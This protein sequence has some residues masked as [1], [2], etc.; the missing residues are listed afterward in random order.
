MSDVLEKIEA[1]AEEIAALGPSNEKL[2]RL[3]DRTA[4]LL[5]ESGVIR[6][7]QPA[8][9]GGAE[10]HPADFA[11]AV[12][13]LAS[14]DGST[15]WV[16][17]IVGVH[18]WEMAMCDP[19]V[20]EEIW[21][22]DHDTWIASPYAPMG[23]I[24]PVD[25]GYVFNGRWQFSSGTDHC[26]WIFLGAYLGDESGEAIM[27]P[28]VHHVILPRSD[29]T[30]VEDSWDV[31]GLRGT[32]SKDIVVKD[33]FIPDY[34]VV[35]FS[36]FTDGSQPRD[37][38]LTNPTYHIPFTTAFPLGITSAVIGIAEG[39]LAA[40][41]AYQRTRV[42]IT[43]TKVKDDPY[44][45]YA[46]SQAAAEIHASRV[47]MLDNARRFYDKAVRGEEVSFA[48]RAESRRTQV[49]AAWRAVNAMD[50]VVARSGG[51]GLRMDNP[52]QRFWRD[53]H[54]GLAHAIHVP[55]SVFHV[56]SLTAMDVT[57]PPGPMLSMI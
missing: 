9:Y 23:V 44:V 34:R 18:P 12:M 50:Q 39:A 55:G 27:P 19:R 1:R 21:G 14:L 51:N 53:G 46:I 25:G 33:A 17:G 3:D 37:A 16:A 24:R 15:G 43:G 22:E 32:G 56:Q 4:E 45:L 40:H 42:Q 10:A 54:M 11:E 41:L 52:I 26:D 13:R 8:K 7:L 28:R 48:E 57:P 38:G 2:G 35:E 30:I 5:R 29:Y 36:R 20:Q 47:T 49:S 31:V 6:M